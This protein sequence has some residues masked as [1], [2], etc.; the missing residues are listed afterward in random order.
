MFLLDRSCLG[1]RGGLP[2]VPSPSGLPALV[3]RPPV[4][5]TPGERVV[6]RGPLESVHV[7]RPSVR[8]AAYSRRAG[9]TALS[10]SS[11]S[12]ATPS[13]ETT[14]PMRNDAGRKL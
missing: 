1:A 4:A 7:S 2:P 9:S 14:R 5:P 11:A 6:L 8:R 12:A 3:G 10:T 13:P